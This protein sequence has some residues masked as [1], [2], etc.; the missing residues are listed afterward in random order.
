VDEGPL[1]LL[2]ALLLAG[3]L[4]AELPLELELLLVPS[5]LPPSKLPTRF[6]KSSILTPLPGTAVKSGRSEV[7]A[8]LSLTAPPP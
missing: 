2:G 8:P 1:L 3:P 7:P 5:D 6:L 4:L